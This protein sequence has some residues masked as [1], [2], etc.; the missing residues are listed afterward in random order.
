MKI[1][2]SARS[3]PVSFV[4]FDIL[5]IGQ[6]AVN[7]LPLMERKTLMSETISESDRLA[8]TRFIEKDGEAFYNAAVDAGLEGV[9]A[10]RKDS[11]YYFGKRSKDWIKMK[12]LLDEDFVVCGYYAK[13]EHA[14]SVI[15][16]TYKDQRMIYQGHVVMGVSRFDYRYMQSVPH[17]RKDSIYSGYPDFEDAVWLEPK[18]VCTVQYMERT[19]GGGLRQPVFRGLQM[20]KRPDECHLKTLF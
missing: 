18:L 9:V 12:A 5:Y 14:I 4:A 7:H 8:L 15:I 1:G 10:K 19:P 17:I 13:G 3:L 20:D 11:K 2:I 6:R 16:G